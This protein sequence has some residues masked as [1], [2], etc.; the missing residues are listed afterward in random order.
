MEEVANLY[1]MIFPNH[2]VLAK[3]ANPNLMNNHLYSNYYPISYHPLIYYFYYTIVY[4]LTIYLLMNPIDVWM[5]HGID[6]VLV[7]VHLVCH[8]DF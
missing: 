5:Y 6:V 7:V 3:M 2:P 8:H 4:H 1:C